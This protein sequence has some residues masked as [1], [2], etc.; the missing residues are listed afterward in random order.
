MALH[1]YLDG[2]INQESRTDVMLGVNCIWTDSLFTGQFVVLGASTRPFC[3]LHFSRF[4]CMI[5]QFKD[6]YLVSIWSF[7][8]QWMSRLSHVLFKWL[9]SWKALM[10][11]VSSQPLHCQ[12]KKQIQ[13]Y[14]P[15]MTDI[16]NCC[17]H[18]NRSALWSHDLMAV[19]F[20]RGVWAIQ[21]SRP[22]LWTLDT[23]QKGEGT[24]PH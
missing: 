2:F 19:P 3:S 4:G 5:R 10:I 9:L 15:V 11:H 14:V 21:G 22:S 7:M 17:C 6:C 23:W 24:L 13:I 18:T 1:K 16:N 12:P 8:L 20:Q